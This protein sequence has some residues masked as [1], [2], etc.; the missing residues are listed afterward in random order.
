MTAHYFRI[1]AVDPVIARDGRP[2]GLNQGTKM[3][4]LAWPLPSVMAG[5][6]RTGMVKANGQ[7]SYGGNI[8][9]S[10]IALEIWGG[11]PLAASQLYLPRPMDAVGRPTEDGKH[12][13]TVYQVTPCDMASQPLPQGAGCNMPRGGLRPVM[14]TESQSE[15]DFKPVRLPAWWPCSKIVSWL[16]T[17]QPVWD[18]EFFD[19]TFLREPLRDERDHVSIEAERGAAEEGMVF[20]TSGLAL[21]WLPKNISASGVPRQRALV[22]ERMQKVELALAVEDP[23]QAFPQLNQ[24]RFLW[25]MGGERRIVFWSASQGDGD[26]WKCPQAVQEKLSRA[27]RVRM[28]LGTPA[29]FND[30]WKPAWLDHDLTGS[31]PGVS[32]KLK[33]VGVVSDRWQAISGWSLKRGGP[34][35]TRRAVPAGSVYFFE[36]CDESA[37]ELAKLWLR[38]VSDELRERRD[39]F[40][41]A[42]WGVW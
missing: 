20:S 2:F 8:R 35:P 27:K 6:F 25:P 30:G 19:E 16:T 37:A 1:A 21:S 31:P 4:S 18:A 24:L 29:I 7:D 40:G 36:C 10:L 26:L 3:R 28:V 11:F 17:C 38:P 23:Q 42:L 33:L 32:V 13:S 22:P 15:E 34:K 41:V 39:G 14:L 9:N 5:S 12:L